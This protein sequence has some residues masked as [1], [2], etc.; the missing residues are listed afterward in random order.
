MAKVFV[1]E[2]ITS[3]CW[4]DASSVLVIGE[5]AMRVFKLVGVQ[6]KP[7]DSNNNKN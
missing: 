4:D 6:V 1:N 5:V 2:P 7:N 3:S